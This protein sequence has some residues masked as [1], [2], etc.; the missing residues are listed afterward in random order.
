MFLFPPIPSLKEE[1][2]FRRKMYSLEVSSRSTVTWWP[3][4]RESLPRIGAPQ[5]LAFDSLMKQ[6]VV[7]RQTSDEQPITPPPRISAPSFRRAINQRYSVDRRSL[8][9]TKRKL[10]S[11]FFFY[12]IRE[13]YKT[14]KKCSSNFNNLFVIGYVNRYISLR[15]KL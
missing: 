11:P 8:Q 15:I 12:N 9:F 1:E 13:I 6:D 3:S 14:F 10:S 2:S 5:E 4:N 7:V